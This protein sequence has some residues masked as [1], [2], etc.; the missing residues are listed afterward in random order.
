MKT[1]CEYH[2]L[3]TD[4]EIGFD[5]LVCLASHLC[6]TPVSLIS[7]IDA[8]RQWFK[9]KVGLEIAST[10]RDIA[11]C[12]HTI[13]Q[14]EPLVVPDTHVDDRFADN[15][16]V[17]HAPY[18]RFYAGV[19]LIASH[20]HKIGT[21]C[22]IDLVPR[23]LLPSQIEALQALGR[24]VVAQLELR[25]K[26][27]ETEHLVQEAQHQKSILRESEERFRTIA[28][29]APVLIWVDDPDRQAVFYNQ[30]WLKFTGRSLEQEL[31]E[32]WKHGLH[33]DDRRHWD[34][35]YNAAFE[36]RIPYTIEYRLRH[37][38]GEYRWVQEKGVPR[39]LNDRIFAGFTGS[40]VD[41]TDHKTKEQGHQF[42]QSLT[43]A[44]VSSSDFHSA[45]GVALQK[46]CEATQWEFGE[47]WIPSADKTVME[48][49]P[50]WYSKA[51]HLADFRKASETFTF[52][53]GFG[54]PGRVWCSKQTEWHQDVSKESTTT[55]LRAQLALDAG[56]KA[57]LG[58]PLLANNE[59]IT[60]LVF[61]MFEA[62][63]E[64]QRLIDLIAASTELGFF[65]QRKQ[66]EEEVR[67]LLAQEREL[68]QFKSNFIANVS[69]E[70]RT[71]LT[72][73]IGLSSVLLEQ[74]YG[75]I[76]D[77]QEQYLAL[78]HSSGQHLLN[79]INDLLDLAK[80]EAGRQELNKEHVDVAELCQSAIQMMESQA[81]AK[82]QTFSLAL[83]IAIESIE[84]DRQRIFQV[85]LNFLSNAVKFS[86]E[87]GSITLTSRLASGRELE[88]IALPAEEANQS[89]CR[90]LPT[91]PF[92]VIEVS[93]TGEGIPSEKQHLLFQTFQQID[94]S[95]SSQLTGSG[96]GLALTKQ[97]AELHGGRVSFSSTAGVGSTF[98][99]WLPIQNHET[100]IVLHDLKSLASATT[101]SQSEP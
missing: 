101:D 40:C 66:A 92:L 68:N 14:S 25:K 80:I 15:P 19:P 5:D 11:F 46:V 83:P 6:D 85:L 43:N 35:Q 8:E 79:L 3:D 70:L 52:P 100:P 21:L 26:L 74:Y 45:L 36:A 58:I 60:V 9:S 48:C 28:N 64:D 97:L 98:S 16:L 72:A 88:A 71:P 81:T 44:I 51:A 47:A 99:V 30:T 41:I 39:F 22:V 4:P 69:H 61:Y 20:G 89:L 95:N 33:P 73:V 84:V 67:T 65:I 96:L 75:S 77:K 27:Q 32:G 63:Q 31:R 34:E 76:N 12:S 42:L 24:Q 2:V 54:I 50:A 17:V 29:S 91:D 57:T 53:P 59:V 94:R 87:G 13:L 37:A 1:L 10:P 55:Y 56:L 23:Q 86:S 82:Q 62:R 90:V 7:L 78:I 18:I 49:S 93:D 38:D